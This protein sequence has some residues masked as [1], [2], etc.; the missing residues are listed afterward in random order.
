MLRRRADA[1]LSFPALV[2]EAQRRHRHRL[3]VRVLQRD[4]VGIPAG[5]DLPLAFQGAV[6]AIAEFEFL[7]H[8]K[9]FDSWLISVLTSRASSRPIPSGSLRPRRRT[10]ARWSSARST[11]DGAAW[12]GRPWASRYETSLRD[13]PRLTARASA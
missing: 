9:A 11:R 12:S 3:C 2:L 8:R 7:H 10:R 13:S 5:A 4:A 1:Q 6:R